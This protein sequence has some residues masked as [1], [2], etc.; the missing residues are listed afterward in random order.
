MAAG[1][2]LMGVDFGTGGVR[3]GIFDA[4]GMPRVFHGVEFGTSYPRSGWAEQDPDVWWSSFLQA[5]K[6][7]IAD[8]GVGAEDIVGIS[9]DATASTVL[10]IGQDERHLGK[11]IMWMDVRAADQAA[12]LAATQDKALKYCGF[13]DVS[14]EWGLPKALWLKEKQPHVWDKT[15]LIV[16]CNDWLGHQLTGEWA[17]SVNILAC[18]YF[19]DG[20]TGGHARSLM[21]AVGF[22]DFL[23]KVPGTVLNLGDVIGQLRSAV[24][25]EIGLKA[26]IPVAMGAIDAHS[27]ALGLG[28]VEPGK[29]AL[30]T[31]SSHVMIGQ[32]SEPVHGRGFWG[33]YTDA[34]I[35]GQYTVEAG[36]VSTGS[37]VAWFKN[38]FASEAAVDAHRRGVDAYAVLNDL[39]AKVPIGSNGLVF[40]D[41]FQGNRSP[42]TD[43]MVRGAIW[44]LGLGHGTGD[45]FRSILEGICFGTESIFKAMREQNFTPELNV[46]S[47]G[48]TK[49]KLWMQMHA[50]VSNVPIATTKVTDGPALGSA[51]LA[52]VGAG[53][54]MDVQEAAHNMV[55]TASSIEPNAEAHE[56]YSFYQEKYEQTYPALRDLMAEMTKHEASRHDG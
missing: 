40:L 48:P 39:A 17:S 12:A 27:G 8:S 33:S 11:A 14:A 23:D 32:A 42:H 45:V 53:L 2:H 18:K 10:A 31:G 29:L 36:Q 5:A 34:L 35:P 43:P 54:Y 55:H 50:D 7:A 19:Y 15:K 26:G 41:Y 46:V 13:G 24:A 37:V 52:A 21:E 38:K 20:D 1:P 4:Q 47:G 25:D 49:S 44:G 51:M 56:R 16:D 3:V 22:T 28:V 9:T 6:K 30:I